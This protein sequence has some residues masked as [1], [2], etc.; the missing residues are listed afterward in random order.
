[1]KSKTYITSNVHYATLV[2]PTG[3][4]LS[5]FGSLLITV[6][7]CYLRHRANDLAISREKV[8]NSYTL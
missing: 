3:R 4:M 7:R 1:M 8:N 6:L 2:H 5:S